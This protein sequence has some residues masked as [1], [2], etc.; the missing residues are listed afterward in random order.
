MRR[1][2]RDTSEF[3]GPDMVVVRRGYGCEAVPVRTPANLEHPEGHDVEP[4]H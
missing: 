2:E 1:V 4:V 3:H